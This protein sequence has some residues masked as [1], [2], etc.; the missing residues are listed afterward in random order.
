MSARFQLVID[1]ADPARQTAFWAG[2]LGYVLEPAPAGHATWKAYY[3]SLGV[4]EDEL[5]EMA[6]DDV[7]S[8][9]DPDGVGPR[10]WFQPVPEGKVV[11]NRLHLDL[12]IADRTAAL[13][14]RREQ[15]DTEV[16]RLTG[17]GA[18][19]V[20]VLAEPGQDHYA[21]TMH[22]PKATS[23]ACVDRDTSDKSARGSR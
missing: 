12:K 23:S 11:K 22:D 7:D 20:R 1:C 15:V 16:E 17:L 3:Q 4:P 21:V 18:S 8:V 5:E 19:V 13:E 14:T 6:D 9:V 10:I 2:A